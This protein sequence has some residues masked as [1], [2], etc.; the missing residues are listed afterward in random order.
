MTYD[1]EYDSYRNG[2][3]ISDGTE[4]G[5]YKIYDNVSVSET[6]AVNGALFFRNGTTLWVSRGTAD[7]N[8]KFFFSGFH[9]F[10][11]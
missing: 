5:A 10:F 6:L 4:D 1:A 7:F 3:W 9:Q 8:R 2:L 11:Y